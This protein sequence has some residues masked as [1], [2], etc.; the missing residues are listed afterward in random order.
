MK[1][2][3]E[4]RQIYESGS[5]CICKDSRQLALINGPSITVYDIIELQQNSLILQLYR[6][7]EEVADIYLLTFQPFE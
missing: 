4:S 2:R 5:W 1:A 3:P 6:T 7:R